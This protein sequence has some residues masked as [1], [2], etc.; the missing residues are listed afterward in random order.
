M[1]KA[2]QVLDSSSF[3]APGGV[4]AEI[5]DQVRDDKVAAHFGD[6]ATVV[7]SG[8]APHLAPGDRVLH[9]ARGRARAPGP[10]QLL[11]HAAVVARVFRALRRARRVRAPARRTQALD[12]H[13]PVLADPLRDQPWGQRSAAVAAAAQEQ[14]VIDTVL[15]P[16]DALYLPRGVAARGDGAG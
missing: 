9:P 6:G 11:R 13:A 5:G 4:G 10:G 14:P 7:P 3:T 16:G 1:A 8:P 15:E 12:D 2:G